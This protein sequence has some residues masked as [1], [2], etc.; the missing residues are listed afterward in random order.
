RLGTPRKVVPAGT[1][2]IGGQQTGI[3]PIPTPGGW[4]LLGRTNFTLFDVN[5]EPPCPVQAGDRVTFEP[6]EELEA[7][8]NAHMTS[9]AP[10]PGEPALE[11][12]TPG[13]FTTV[14]DLGRWGYQASGVSVAGA[15][16]PLA[17]RA[18]NSLVGNEAGAAALEITLLGPSLRALRPC[19]VALAGAEVEAGING[20]V[21]DLNAGDELE[22]GRTLRGARAYLAIAGGIDVPVVLG[23]RST[24][25]RAGIGGL[26]GRAL[27]AGDVLAVGL[28]AS[29]K[30]QE[31]RVD[32][33]L[34]LGD[35]LTVRVV[36]GPQDDYFSA[37]TIQ[38][39]LSIP[40]RIS[41]DADRMAYRLGGHPLKHRGPAEI[42][43]DGVVLGSIQV[44]PH[45]NPI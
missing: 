41:S 22:I 24:Y 23:S 43:S 19:T 18:A 31:A 5:A 25:T 6:V 17:L 33:D 38:E 8:E 39:F 11:V 2:G 16:D 1:V 3:Y 37:E 28:E 15:M 32:F 40:F 30:R 20:R 14:Q 10:A 12:L 35:E 26:E 36:F 9:A 7:G 27:R 44:P 42:V 21:V 45:G 13:L 4:R 29:G 34:P